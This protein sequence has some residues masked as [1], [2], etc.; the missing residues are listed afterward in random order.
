M[1]VF[2]CN[3]HMS[4]EEWDRW[5][6]YIDKCHEQDKPVLLPEYIDLLADDEYG[7]EVEYEEE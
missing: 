4:V 7:E 3:K 1:L 2:K 6:S 5:R